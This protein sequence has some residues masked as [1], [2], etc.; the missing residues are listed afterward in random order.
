MAV[1][2]KGTM[3][4]NARG[5]PQAWA[6]GSLAPLWKYYKVSYALCKCFYDI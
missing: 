3:S 5:R 6:R 4:I 2:Q 1:C